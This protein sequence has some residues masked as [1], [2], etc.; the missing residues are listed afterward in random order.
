MDFKGIKDVECYLRQ[1]IRSEELENKTI[2]KSNQ[3]KGEGEREREQDR[4]AKQ[5]GWGKRR[6]RY[7]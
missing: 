1:R 4:D 2:K 6:Y 3:I 7:S 5:R